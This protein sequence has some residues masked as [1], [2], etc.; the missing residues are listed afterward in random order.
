M[1]GSDKARRKE[2]LRRYKNTERSAAR[3]QLG[4]TADDLASLLECLDDQLNNV[5]CDHT[6]RLTKQ[7]A[8]E[9]GQSVEAITNAVLSFGGYCD[10]EVLANV[11]PDKFGWPD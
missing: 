10:C 3:E 9:H 4:L 6:L 2:L 11:T 1:S 7:W 8:Q 5:E